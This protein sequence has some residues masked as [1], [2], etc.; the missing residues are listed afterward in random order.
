MKQTFKYEGQLAINLRH[1]YSAR[2]ANQKHR[3]AAWSSWAAVY[4]PLP[5]SLKKYIFRQCLG[6]WQWLCK[7]HCEV[8]RYIKTENP[9]MGVHVQ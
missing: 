4:P 8:S 2:R 6:S 9:T 7:V 5:L 3:R 1:C